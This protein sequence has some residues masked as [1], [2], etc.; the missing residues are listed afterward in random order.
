MLGLLGV[1]HKQ[2]RMC[3]LLFK[4]GQYLLQVFLLFEPQLQLFYGIDGLQQ[5]GG[6][7]FKCAKRACEFGEAAHTLLQCG[8][9]FFFAAFQLGQLVLK[10]W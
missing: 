10:L 1:F 6:H 7:A 8:Q 9:F 5:V 2:E 3:N 4:I